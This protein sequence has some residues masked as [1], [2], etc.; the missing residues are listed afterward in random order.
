M[1]NSSKKSIPPNIFP[2]ISRNSESIIQIHKATRAIIIH[3]TSWQGIS[4]GQSQFPGDS[5]WTAPWSLSTGCTQSLDVCKRK[6]LEEKR[7]TQG[8]V[9]RVLY[10]AKTVLP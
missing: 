7:S 8:Y 6:E 10:T 5:P 3:T 2:Q 9:I 4:K 1:Y